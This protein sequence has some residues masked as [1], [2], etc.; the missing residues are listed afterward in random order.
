M[1][2]SKRHLRAV[3]FQK[4]GKPVGPPKAYHLTMEQQKYDLLYMF[5]NMFEVEK[6]FMY[7]S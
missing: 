7:E 2:M 6:Y 5:T 1:I 3:I 4:N